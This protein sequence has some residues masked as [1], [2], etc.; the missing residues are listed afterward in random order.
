MYPGKCNEMRMEMMQKL[1][2]NK[3]RSK[4]SKRKN[5]QMRAAMISNTKDK[6]TEI[7]LSPKKRDREDEIL[8]LYVILNL[9]LLY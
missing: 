8:F 1:R 3:K 4:L 2:F 7:K 9:H 5:R 6:F